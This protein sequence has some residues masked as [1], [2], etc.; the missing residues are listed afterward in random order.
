ML[1]VRN[2]S[3]GK[4]K[5]GATLQDARELTKHTDDMSKV[6]V[7]AAGIEPASRD[8][9][10]KASTCVADCLFLAKSVA[11]RQGY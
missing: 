10:I 4:N 2:I 11:Y 5:N 9:F 1:S 3:H 6:P 8:I 7:E